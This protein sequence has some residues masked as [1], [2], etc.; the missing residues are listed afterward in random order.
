M[1]LKYVK[2][3]RGRRGKVNYSRKGLSERDVIGKG[4]YRKRSGGMYS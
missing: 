4:V 3:K 2:T 1:Q